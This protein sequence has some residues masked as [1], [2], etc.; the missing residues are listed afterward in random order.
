MVNIRL[1]SP[2]ESKQVVPNIHQL[3]DLTQNEPILGM[4]NRK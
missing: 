1:P 4:K 3:A 2:S